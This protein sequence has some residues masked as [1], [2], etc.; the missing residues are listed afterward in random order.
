[1]E[2]YLLVN[3]CFL[4]IFRT[5]LSQEKYLGCFF[6]YYIRKECLIVVIPASFLIL[7]VCHGADI[8]SS[9]KRLFS[10]QEKI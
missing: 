2:D 5:L 10:D 1:M 7:Y 9:A 6:L 3:R 4:F 8:N